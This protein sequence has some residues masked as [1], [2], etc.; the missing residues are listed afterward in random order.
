MRDASARFGVTTAARGSR[1]RTS[2]STASSARS[3]APCLLIITGS[4]TSG[5]AKDAARS[6]IASIIAALPS[7]PVFAACGGMSASTVRSV[8]TASP[9]APWRWNALRSA[10]SPA[11]PE[12]SEP[13]MVSAT[14]VRAMGSSP[15]SAAAQSVV[16]R[17]VPAASPK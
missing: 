17:I 10:C 13:A 6:A 7:A 14:G 12:G 5:K 8:T 11:P 16:S 1:R 4:T 3:G 9:Y 2:A 15:R